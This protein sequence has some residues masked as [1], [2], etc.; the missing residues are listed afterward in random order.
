MTHICIIAARFYQDITDELIR[1]AAAMLESA[2]AAYDVIEVP[3]AFEIPAALSMAIESEKYNGYVTLGCVIRGETT[4]YEY[5]C[6]ESAYGINQLASVFHAPV[7]YGVLTVEN[8]EQAWVRAALDQGN[9]GG[10]A[11]RACLHM[12]EVKKALMQKKGIDA[13]E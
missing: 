13:K 10:D 7:G 4:H 8:K 6:K 2:G 9:K 1:G 5:V 3:G 11:A 12:L